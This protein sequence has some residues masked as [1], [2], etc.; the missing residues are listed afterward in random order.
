MNRYLRLV[1]VLFLIAISVV[2]CG[3]EQA[4]EEHVTFEQLFSSSEKY[5]GRQIALEGFYFG[6]FEVCVLSEV[7]DYY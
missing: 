4:D 7:L 2:N 6:G 3:G 1:I 5:D